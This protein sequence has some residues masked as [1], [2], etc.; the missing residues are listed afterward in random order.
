MNN[1]YGEAFA[2]TLEI[3]EHSKK[4]IKDKIS[5]KFIEFSIISNVSAKASP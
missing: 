5:A 3:I 1:S 4:E 2:E